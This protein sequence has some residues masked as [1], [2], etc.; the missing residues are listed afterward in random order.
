VEIVSKVSYEMLNPSRIIAYRDGSR[1]RL[2]KKSLS[3]YFTPPKAGQNIGINPEP[4]RRR[5][6]W[7]S[8]SGAR[9]P[10]GQGFC[11]AKSG[12]IIITRFFYGLA[13][14]YFKLSLSWG[15]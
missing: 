12:F 9:L 1:N 5:R 11:F 13:G 6:V 8:P 14:C 15:G 4:T 3:Q 7:F 2:K 10:D